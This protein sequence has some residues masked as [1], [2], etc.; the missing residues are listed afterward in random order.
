[1]E[2]LDSLD[3]WYGLR[4][5]CRGHSRPHGH[6]GSGPDR[7]L[8]LLPP[9]QRRAGLDHRSQ[10]HRDLRWGH[11]GDLFAHPRNPGLSSGH[12]GWL[13]DGSSRQGVSRPVP[14]SLVFLPRRS[15][16]RRPAD[17]CGPAACPT[18]PQVQF[19]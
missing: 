3:P 4:D 11:T 16:W 2:H 8:E 12:L 17:G 5:L 9:G 7:S 6:H 19:L 1:M 14:G 10:L 15:H 13:P 18:S